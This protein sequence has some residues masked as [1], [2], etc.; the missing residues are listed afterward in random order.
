MFPDEN[1]PLPVML[2]EVIAYLFAFGTSMY[3]VYYYYKAF[4]L[5][6]LKFF[7]TFGSLI[8]LFAPFLFL[9]VVPYYITGDLVWSRRL[10][11][12]IPF[13]YGVSFIVATTRAFIFKFREKEYSEKTKFELVIAAYVALLCWVALPVI[14]FFGDFQVLEHSITNSGF[15]IMTIVYIRSSIYQSRKEYNILLDRVHSLEQLIESNC[16]KYNLTARE[17][18]IVRL[19]MK[20]H[21]Y[22]II[23]ADLTISEKTVAKHVSNIFTKA[24]ASNKVELIN[25]LEQKDHYVE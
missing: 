13:L 12:V 20:G 8:F 15:L 14:V 3:F 5:K 10:A 4:D 9:F 22:K 7:V 17:I 16:D 21:S 25:K 23:A 6:R 11:V 24:S 1:I 19:I 2:Q 18:E